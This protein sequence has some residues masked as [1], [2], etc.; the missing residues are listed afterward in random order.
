[1]DKEIFLVEELENRLAIEAVQY[2]RNVEELWETIKFDPTHFDTFLTGPLYS[3]FIQAIYDRIKP[4]NSHEANRFLTLSVAQFKT[5][6]PERRQKDFI[7]NYWHTK[8]YPN[9][10]DDK[11]G[12]QDEKYAKFVWKHYT[13]NFHLY[14]EATEKGLEDFKAGLL[15]SQPN[16]IKETGNQPIV[17]KD[18]SL[19]IFLRALEYNYPYEYTPLNFKYQMRDNIDYLKL[20]VLDNLFTLNKDDRLPYL[21]KIKYEIGNKKQYAQVTESD[22]NVWLN[23]YKVEKEADIGYSSESNSLYQILNSETPTIDDEFEENFNRDTHGIQTDF[24]NYYYGFYID[25]AVN[26]IEE[27]ISKLTPVNSLSSTGSLAQQSSQAITPK[28]KVNITVPQ[29]AYLFKMLNDVKPSIFNIEAKTELSNFITANFITKATE[30][31]GIKP[32]S[33]YNLFSDTDKKVANY[34]VDILKKML[35]DARK[36]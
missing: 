5:H 33:V 21:N 12:E 29:L 20:E 28:L 15:G 36:V 4:L 7:L 22:I 31:E 26:F 10:I 23:K 13:K 18:Q 34:W 6:T 16:T 30:K 25:A 3:E 8:W 1:M 35:E 9:A 19:L 11:V 2:M 17:L 27:H 14:K 24:Y 32:K